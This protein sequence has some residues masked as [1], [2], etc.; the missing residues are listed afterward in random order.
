MNRLLF[1]LV[2]LL[3]GCQSAP[4]HLTKE[5]GL[6]FVSLAKRA[7]IDSHVL[8][9]DEERKI[10]TTEPVIAYYFLARPFA[11]YSARWK[12]NEDEELIVSGRGD[13]LRL[14]NVT[15]KRKKPNRSP[16]PT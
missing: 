4:S 10:A 13:I 6:R 15:V 3:A 8:S 12:L 14:E 2:L 1:S 16:A 9:P 7:A 5:E 11:D